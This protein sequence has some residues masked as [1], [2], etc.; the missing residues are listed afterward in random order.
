MRGFAIGEIGDGDVAL[1]RRPARIE[2]RVGGFERLEPVCVVLIQP[3]FGAHAVDHDIDEQ[4]DAVL[5]RGIGEL[6]QAVGGAR[7]AFENRVQAMMI[8]DGLA[9]PVTAGHER[10][11]D[12][13]VVEAERPR[14]RTGPA[15]R[16]AGRREGDR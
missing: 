14:A 5:F 1:T 12:Q 8:G 16:R 11:A 15:T 4:R 9:M 10:R 2:P 13:D 7:V 3:A 6:A